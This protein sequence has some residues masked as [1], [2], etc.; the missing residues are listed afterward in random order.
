MGLIDLSP[1]SPPPSF[2]Y[3]PPPDDGVNVIYHDADILVLEKPS[4]LLSVPGKPP[5]HGDCLETRAQQ[6]FP[7]ARTVHRLDRETSGVV[8]MGRT[9]AAHR[10]LSWQFESRQ[11][12]KTYVAWVAGRVAALWGRIDLP[13][14]ADWPNR[15]KQHVNFARGRAAQTDWRVTDRQMGPAGDRTTRLRLTPITGRSHQLRVHLKSIGHPI[16][17]DRFYAGEG[18]AAHE[19]LQLHAETLRLTHPETGAE[20]LFT[21]PAPF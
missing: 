17:G 14:I 19:R 20:H 3:E 18:A 2:V 6:A 9:A 12:T 8:V 15:P 13:L 4:G 7:G 21:S 11:V 5:D 1:N 16:L 10:H